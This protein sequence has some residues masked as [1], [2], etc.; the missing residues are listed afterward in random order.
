[1]NDIKK[2]IIVDDDGKLIDIL[3]S[4]LKD[5]SKKKIK[6]LI[7][8]RMVLVNKKVVTNSSI[9]VKKGDRVTIYFKKSNH[10][11]FPLHI[12]YEDSDVIVIDKPSGLLSISSPKEKYNTAFR[13]VSD[14]LK[15]TDR[16]AKLFVV[17]RLDE[18]TSGVLLFAK[19]LDIKEKLQDN[20]N[21]LVKLREYICVVEG[22]MPKKG[23]FKTYLTMNHFQKVY[24]TKNKEIG[25]LAI[26]NYERIKTN[27]KYSLLKVDIETGK[28]N[29][30]RVHMS[31]YGHPIVGD[32]KY[33][34]KDNSIGRLA[35]HASKLKIT[36]P[37]TG[38]IMS[39]EAKTPKIITDIVDK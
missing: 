8:Y 7:K 25:K 4:N 26:T 24:S 14:Y 11:N 37:K 6:S 23:T 33:G 29:Q 30:I 21:N 1:M 32:K 38:K 3:V 34:S 17:H 9:M 2:E 16:K 35:L 15:K 39:F 20:W 36:N 19:N 22:E 10:E 18:D 28:R 5:I 31:E 12:I 27:K 13:L